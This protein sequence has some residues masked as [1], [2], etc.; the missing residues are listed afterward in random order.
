MLLFSVHSPC[1][2][3]VASSRMHA[4]KCKCTADTKPWILLVVLLVSQ[5]YTTPYTLM[6]KKYLLLVEVTIHCYSVG[7]CFYVCTCMHEYVTLCTHI[8]YVYQ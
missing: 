8:V 7:M 3:E 1:L 2:E 5:S 4:T 6:R